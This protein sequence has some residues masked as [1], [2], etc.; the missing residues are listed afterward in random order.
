MDQNPQKHLRVK[1]HFSTFWAPKPR[2]YLCDWCLTGSPMT[3]TIGQHRVWLL[4]RHRAHPTMH[5]SQADCPQPL[6]L[7]RCPDRRGGTAGIHGTRAVGRSRA[8]GGRAA[9][10]DEEVWNEEWRTLTET[11]QHRVDKVKK[12]RKKCWRLRVLEKHQDHVYTSINICP[13][14][15]FPSI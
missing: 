10:R 3:R 8:A 6:W 4:G 11:Q 9:N 1:V 15:C 5:C 7:S 12:G 2:F 13:N 14:G